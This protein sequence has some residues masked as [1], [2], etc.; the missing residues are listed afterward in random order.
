MFDIEEIG[1]QGL[2]A[3]GL[4]GGSGGGRE[5]IRLGLEAR[6]VDVVAEQGMANRGQVD[7]NLMGAAGLQPAGQ[8][9][10][11]GL[12]IS[13]GVPFEDLPM[14]DRLATAL[15]DRHFVAGARV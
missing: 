7:P 5:V 9:A 4:E 15:A 6:P 13:A 1:M 11:D 2:S 14:G 10:G 12:A 3:K 8:K